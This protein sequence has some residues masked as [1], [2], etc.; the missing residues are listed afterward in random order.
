MCLLT[1]AL[2]CVSHIVVFHRH[3][4]V[5]VKWH[6]CHLCWYSFLSCYSD[7]FLVIEHLR[8]SKEYNFTFSICWCCCFWRVCSPKK[9]SVNQKV[10]RIFITHSWICYNRLL[11]HMSPAT[12]TGT[13]FLTIPGCLLF[14]E[15]NSFIVL[16]CKDLGSSDLWGSI[17]PSRRLLTEDPA[18]PVDCCSCLQSVMK[19]WDAMFHGLMKW[20][21]G[22]N[23]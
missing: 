1:Y 12:N 10:W 6:A 8:W 2:L 18:E 21:R 17:F 7:Q 20:E 19:T 15:L 22:I 13:C 16:L 14:I 5:S 4:S 23:R 3:R 11:S 9:I